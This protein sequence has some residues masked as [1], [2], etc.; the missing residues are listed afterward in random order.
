MFLRTDPARVSGVGQA[1]YEDWKA[2]SRAVDALGLSLGAPG[3]LSATAGEPAERI[4]GHLLDDDLVSILGLRARLGRVFTSDD[5]RFGTPGSVIVISHRLW[6]G[7]FN[8]DPSI[9]GRRIRLNRSPVTVIGVAH[10]AFYYPDDRIDFWAPM[11]ALRP[12]NRDDARL[13]GVVGRLRPGVTSEQAEAELQAMTRGEWS[14]RA[15]SL[16]EVFFGWAR[17]PVS[18]VAVAVALVLLMSCANVAA[19]LLARGTVRAPELALRMALGA[20]RGRVVRQLLAESVLLSLVGGALGLLVAWVSVGALRTLAPLP[21]QLAIPPVA[22]DARLMGIAG[23]LATVTAFVFG[24]IPALRCSVVRPSEPLKGLRRGGTR[25]HPQVLRGAL[26]AGQIAV[27]FVLV[28]GAALLATSFARLTLR[29]LHFDPDNLITFDFRV[30]ALE[31]VRPGGTGRGSVHHEITSLPAATHDRVLARL[32]LLPG[33]ESAA[34]ISHHPTNTI[35]L[36]RAPLTVLDPD[37]QLGTGRCRRS[38]TGVLSRHTGF[39]QDDE[40]ADRPRQGVRRRRHAVGAVGG[41]GE[42]EPRPAALAG[43]GRDWQADTAGRVA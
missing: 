16:R 35:V 1:D 20:G 18:T 27:A 17:H 2:R 38:P 37:W 25:G 30:P 43:R 24:L 41:R 6:T 13:Y 33:V 34:G 40:N 11:W 10:P 7:R 29:D 32:T 28:T 4:E 23:V 22:I 8:A 19:L 15:R 36:A 39:L 12:G 21:G 3:D 26:V 31:F 5:P 14:V 9:V 42:R